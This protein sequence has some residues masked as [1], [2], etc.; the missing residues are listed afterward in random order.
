MIVAISYFLN[1][2]MR[3]LWSF[4]EKMSYLKYNFFYEILESAPQRFKNTSKFHEMMCDYLYVHN[5]EGFVY[6]SLYKQNNC[7]L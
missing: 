7:D 2:F 6:F 5:L 1:F 4:F 3:Y